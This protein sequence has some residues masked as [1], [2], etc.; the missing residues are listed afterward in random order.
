MHVRA[1]CAESFTEDIHTHLTPRNESHFVSDM[2]CCCSETVHTD[3]AYVIRPTFE[4]SERK[5]L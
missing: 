4:E 2:P 5:S 3:Y 1:W